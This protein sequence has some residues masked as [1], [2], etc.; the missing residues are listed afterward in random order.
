VREAINVLGGMVLPSVA[1]QERLYRD[2]RMLSI[3][4]GTNELLALIQ[5]REITG[6]AA[7]RD[8]PVR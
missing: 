3:P 4:D 6:L 2:V 7:F 5:G 8:A 1:P